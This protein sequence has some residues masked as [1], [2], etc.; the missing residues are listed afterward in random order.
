MISCKIMEFIVF[1]IMDAVT[2]TY[3]GGFCNGC[4]TKQQRLH[5]SINVS[6]NDLS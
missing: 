2:Y 3:N 1:F 5:N 6:Y 4:I